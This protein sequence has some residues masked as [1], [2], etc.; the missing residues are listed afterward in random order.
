MIKAQSVTAGYSPLTYDII[1]ASWL[2]R[3]IR[4]GRCAGKYLSIGLIA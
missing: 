1:S 2:K 4:L 3:I